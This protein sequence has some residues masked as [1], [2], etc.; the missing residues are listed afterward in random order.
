MLKELVTDPCGADDENLT[1][2][3][4]VDESV[5]DSIEVVGS[6]DGF[7]IICKVA[8][9]SFLRTGRGTR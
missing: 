4:P 6:I 1:K 2:L 7:I 5:C 9:Q 8:L 3:S